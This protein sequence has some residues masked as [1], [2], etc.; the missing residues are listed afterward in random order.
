MVFRQQK[1]WNGSFRTVWFHLYVKPLSVL[2][3]LGYL[4]SFF[5]GREGMFDKSTWWNP[6]SFHR[7]NI[8]KARFLQTEKP[9]QTNGIFLAGQFNGIETMFIAKTVRTN[10]IPIEFTQWVYHQSTS[11]H[12]SIQLHRCQLAELQIEYKQLKFWWFRSEKLKYST[13]WLFSTAS[14]ENIHSFMR[15]RCK[16]VFAFNNLR[17]G[18]MIGKSNRCCQNNTRIN[19]QH[20]IYDT[21]RSS[22]ERPFA[23]SHASWIIQMKQ[24][25]VK[26]N[27]LI[28]YQNM[29]QERNKPTIIL[30]EIF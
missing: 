12:L 13:H 9:H 23:S 20:I 25:Y 10:S 17:S 14:H 11:V 3:A 4:K 1:R 30:S 15:Q 26:K 28:W 18:K 7:E 16:S 2:L 24:K 22:V 8:R 21:F 5:F 29:R 19:H 6:C 27:A